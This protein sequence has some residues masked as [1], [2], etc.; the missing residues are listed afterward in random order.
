MSSS[1]CLDDQVFERTARMKGEASARPVGLGT[2]TRDRCISDGLF[3]A[4]HD[5]T[6]S[7]T[8]RLDGYSSSEYAC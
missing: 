3:D 1:Q 8:T 6:Q 5:R 7:S 2:E 4:R